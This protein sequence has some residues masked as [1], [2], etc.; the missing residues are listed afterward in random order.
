[1]AAGGSGGFDVVIDPSE[2]FRFANTV[3]AFDPA[4]MRSL[5]KRM[6]GIGVEA[7]AQVRETLALPSP[8]GGPGGTG[9]RAALNL[10]PPM[11]RGVELAS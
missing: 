6:R 9:G 5:R 8:S 3:K 1:M 7:V 2:W 11:V 10:D 4:L